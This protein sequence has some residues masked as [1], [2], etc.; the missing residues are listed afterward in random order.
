MVFNGTVVFGE[1]PVRWLGV[2]ITLLL[3]AALVISRP[4][5]SRAP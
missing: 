1:G 2:G 5:K 4:W 3:A